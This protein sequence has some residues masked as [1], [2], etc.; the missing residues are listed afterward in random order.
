ML[1]KMEAS[2]REEVYAENVGVTHL[3]VPGFLMLIFIRMCFVI[4][5]S[6]AVPFLVLE[7]NAVT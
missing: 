6:G 2:S 1:L 4:H 5:T 3:S 7:L